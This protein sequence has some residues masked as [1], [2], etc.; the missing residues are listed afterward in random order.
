MEMWSSLERLFYIYEGELTL[1]VGIAVLLWAGYFLFKVVQRSKERKREWEETR[2]PERL[3]EL[4]A[5]ARRQQ[6]LQTD[7]QQAEVKRLEAIRAEAERVRSEQATAEIAAA[8]RLRDQQE[9]M[10]RAIAEWNAKMQ[11]EEEQNKTEEIAAAKAAAAAIEEKIQEVDESLAA[12]QIQALAKGEVRVTAR[13]DLLQPRDSPSN[14]RIS[15]KSSVIKEQILLI[16]RAMEKE[17]EDLEYVINKMQTGIDFLP[18]QVQETISRWKEGEIYRRSTLD[19]LKLRFRYQAY[20]IDDGL[21]LFYVYSDWI[22]KQRQR[23]LKFISALGTEP[24][25]EESLLAAVDRAEKAEW[26]KNLDINMDVI[27]SL[28]EIRDIY[29]TTINMEHRLKDLETVC[30]KRSDQIIQ[31]Q[32]EPKGLL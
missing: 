20:S 27:A 16:S 13:S 25:Q 17:V 32:W 4:R 29:Q 5:Q 15:M 14:K 22:V 2:S 28:K 6:Q 7:Y 26:S 10:D 24:G 1:A 18:I 31:P 19:D 30:K 11:S 3:A 23:L 21:E 9:E 12:W 8:K